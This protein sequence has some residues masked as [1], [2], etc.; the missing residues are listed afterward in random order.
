MAPLVDGSRLVLS[1]DYEIAL[2]GA[3]GERRGVLVLSGTGSL[4]Y[5]VNAAGKST[6]VGG[7]GYLLGDE[8]SGYWIGLEGLRF[9]LRADDGSGPPTALTAVLLDALTLSTARALI[10]WLYHATTP[11]THDIAALAPLVI[12]QA[13]AGDM[14]AEQI[15]QRAARHLAA[16]AQTAG[17]RLGLTAPSFAFAGGVLASTNPVSEALCHELGLPAMPVP[18]YPPVIGAALLALIGLGKG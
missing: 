13:Q 7:W 16:L 17:T 18:R 5:G 6:L 12:Q 3:M 15:V 9:V 8:G 1:S 2:V 4:A 10:P 11:R 14:A